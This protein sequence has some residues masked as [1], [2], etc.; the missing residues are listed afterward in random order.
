MNQRSPQQMTPDEIILEIGTLHKELSLRI[1]RVHGLAQGLYHRMRR[2]PVDDNTPV[3]IAYAN[4][5][6]RFAGMVNQGVV[7]TVS[8]SKVL[9]RLTPTDAAKPEPP[10]QKKAVQQ[11]SPESSPVEDL[12]SMYGEDAVVEQSGAASED[13]Q[14]VTV[15][16]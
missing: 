15:D 16:A 5:W 2:S 6:M 3:Y 11:P 12:I 10:Q 14:P 13:A 4:A 7:R 1:A 9:R 8:A